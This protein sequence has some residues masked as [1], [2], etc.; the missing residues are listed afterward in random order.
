MENSRRAETLNEK[1]IRWEQERQEFWADRFVKDPDN[2]NL[3]WLIAESDQTKQR[4]QGII[5]EE[6][7]ANE[8]G[9]FIDLVEGIDGIY[10]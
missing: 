5:T 2:K 10:R 1:R 8:S 3:Q 9:S 7:S 6:K 4:I